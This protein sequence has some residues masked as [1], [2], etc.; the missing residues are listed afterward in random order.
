MH[1][2]TLYPKTKQVLNKLSDLSF[3]KGW[4]LA[5]GTGLALQ[6]GHRKSIDLDFFTD[7]FPKRDLLLSDL[8]HLTPT[9]I[10]EAPGTMDLNVHNVK[11]S[12]LEYKY[13][14]LEK[15]VSFEKVKVAS[16]LDISCMKVSAV[17]SRGSKKDF[18]DLYFVL[19]KKTL[20]EIFTAFKKKFEGVEYQKLHLLKSLVYFSDAD[21]DP[22]PDY[23]ENVNWE[24]VKDDLEEKVKEYFSKHI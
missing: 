7:K 18:I 15:L 17:S 1:P 12:F 23:I 5:G 11:V 22:N 14:I 6:L 24:E 10:Q 2:Q 20:D 21:N 3:L 9:I 8:K 4:Y 16:I 13:P 19:Q